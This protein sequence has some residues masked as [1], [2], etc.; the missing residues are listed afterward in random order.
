MN[1]KSKY[2]ER[3]YWTVG[4]VKE[5]LKSSTITVLLLDF[6]T[7]GIKWSILS[8]RDHITASSEYECLGEFLRCI[9]DNYFLPFVFEPTRSANILFYFINLLQQS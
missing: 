2:V 9:N 3:I 1:L 4:R 8:I 6:N 7:N 5:F